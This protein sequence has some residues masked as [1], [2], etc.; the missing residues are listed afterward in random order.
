M[1]IT[2][3]KFVDGTQLATT[4]ST[5]Y[6]AP[7]NTTSQIQDVTVCNTSTG[8]KTVTFYVVENGGSAADATTVID[9]KSIAA[10]ETKTL[11]DLTGFVLEAG[12][13]LRGLASAATSVSVQASGIEIV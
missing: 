1:A 3:K 9:T 2:F 6:T 11:S 8:A 10:N 5:L 13:T 7:A 4:S 12:D